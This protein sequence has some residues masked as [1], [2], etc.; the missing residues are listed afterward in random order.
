MLIYAK[1]SPSPH[2]R[3]QCPRMS[4]EDGGAAFIAGFSRAN[5]PKNQ[6]D[7]PLFVRIYNVA[8]FLREGASSRGESVIER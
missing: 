7:T 8:V 5:L 1:F 3:L 2:R 4:R 6:E